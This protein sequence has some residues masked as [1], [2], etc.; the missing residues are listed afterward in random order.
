MI[1]VILA[2]ACFGGG[3]FLVLGPLGR[4]LELLDKPILRDISVC[5]AQAWSE[6]GAVYF[7][8]GT[9]LQTGNAE[10]LAFSVEMQKCTEEKFPKKCTFHLAPVFSNPKSR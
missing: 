10:D 5:D 3:M 8:D 7:R 9:L 4:C 1:G 2:F 6:A